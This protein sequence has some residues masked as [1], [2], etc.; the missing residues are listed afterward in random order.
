VP[1]LRSDRIYR[2]GD[3]IVDEIKIISYSGFEIDIRKMVGDFSIYEDIYSNFITGSIVFSDSVN[4]VKNT[5]I[6]GDETIFITFYTP[7]VDIVPRRV[8]FKIFKISTYVRGAAPNAIAVRLEFVSHIAEVSARTKLNK[9]MRNMKFSDMVDSVYED[10]RKVDNQLP[11]LFLGDETFG[12]STA[13]L[14]YW[15]PLYAINWFCHRSVSNENTSIADFL[16]YETLD[17]ANFNSLSRLKLGNPVC[18]YK[19]AP[20][21]FRSNSG[22]RMIESELRNITS[23][24]V[25]DL[26]DKLKETQQGVYASGMLVHEMTTKSYYS[27]NYSYRSSF[28]K[29]PHLNAGRMLTYDSVAQDKFLAHTKYYS[30][31]YNLYD[32]LEDTSFIDRSQDRQSLLNQMNALTMTIDVY[33]DTTLR[34]GNIVNLEFFSQEYTKDKN[35]FLDAYLS[36][37]YMITTILHNVVDGVHT[38]RMTI[39]RDS[40]YELLPDKKEKTLS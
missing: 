2:A 26:G 21:G 23:Y 40:Y 37:R 30:K 31:S 10:M 9:V 14:P 12:K 38:M 19:S 33:G 34:V 13:I 24:A 27:S 20:G 3:V 7:G 29:T 1:E 16:F 6:I 32:Y 22:D 25:R 4:L 11:E 35:D 17:G 36:G 8:R 18:T 5:P 28:D 39:A 15:P